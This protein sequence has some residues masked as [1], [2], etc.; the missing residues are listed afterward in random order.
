[1]QTYYN[2]TM[3]LKYPSDTNKRIMEHVTNSLLGITGVKACNFDE[4]VTGRYI[5]YLRYETQLVTKNQLSVIVETL[6][7]GA[8]KVYERNKNK[9]Y[10]TGLVFIIL[11]LSLLAIY[12][13]I[14]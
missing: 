11:M 3:R 12:S 2:F 6:V 14:I 5:I 8:T 7:E 4:V 13:F 9:Q 10:W 1:M